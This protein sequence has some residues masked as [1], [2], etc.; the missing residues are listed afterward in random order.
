VSTE[1]SSKALGRKVEM[2]ARPPLA[3]LVD[4]TTF[5][6]PLPPEVTQACPEPRCPAQ[7]VQPCPSSIKSDSTTTGQPGPVPVLA[8]VIPASVEAEIRRMAD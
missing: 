4:T 5:P 1:A 3:W 7:T 6:C 8:P 2:T